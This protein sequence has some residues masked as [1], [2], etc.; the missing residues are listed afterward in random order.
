MVISIY[1][2]F[3]D[4]SSISAVKKKEYCISV[5]KSTD[6]R[7][8]ILKERIEDGSATDEDKARLELMLESL[9]DGYKTDFN[10]KVLFKLNLL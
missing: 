2:I 4:G 5:P 10:T 8:K 6:W 1:F 3:S 9:G 7:I